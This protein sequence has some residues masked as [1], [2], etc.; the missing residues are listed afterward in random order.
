MDICNTRGTADALPAFEMVIRSLLVIEI[1]I[2]QAEQIKAEQKR[3]Q[4]QDHVNFPRQQSNDVDVKENGK[5]RMVSL[6]VPA[7]LNVGSASAQRRLSIGSTWQIG[8][9]HEFTLRHYLCT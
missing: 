5:A 7:L 8:A 1:C 2:K 6:Q 3:A 4:S 9:W